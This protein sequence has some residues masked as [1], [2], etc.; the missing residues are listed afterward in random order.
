MAQQINRQVSE[1]ASL[2]DETHLVVTQSHL[3]TVQLDE[4]A[5]R[6]HQELSTF[7]LQENQ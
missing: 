3:Q 4:A 6:I 5:Q 1:V 7:R 2:A